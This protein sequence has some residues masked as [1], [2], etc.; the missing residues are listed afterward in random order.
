MENVRKSIKTS[1][2]QTRFNGENESGYSRTQ[3]L[4]AMDTKKL[5]IFNSDKTCQTCKH[6]D[7]DTVRTGESLSTSMGKCKGIFERLTTFDSGLEGYLPF[8]ESFVTRDTFGCNG[9]EQANNGN[10]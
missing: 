9:Y 3:T 4:D 1:T 5:T 10:L 2:F 7:A 6:W 8:F